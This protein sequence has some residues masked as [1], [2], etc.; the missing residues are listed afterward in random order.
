MILPQGTSS[1]ELACRP[2]RKF[3]SGEYLTRPGGSHCRSAGYVPTPTRG[4]RV[5]LCQLIL[6]ATASPRDSLRY[7][8]SSSH[9][10]WHPRDRRSRGKSCVSLNLLP[11]PPVFRRNTGFYPAFFQNAGISP[12]PCPF[13]IWVSLPDYGVFLFRVS[14]PFTPRF[15]ETRGDPTVLSSTHTRKQMSFQPPPTSAYYS[16]T[17]L[18]PGTKLQSSRSTLASLRIPS[19]KTPYSW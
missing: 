12:F 13:K 4:H 8:P 5:R 18:S 19:S 1:V 9:L 17:L 10:G 16:H 14:L 11:G 6:L 2:P 15:F 3:E 7:P